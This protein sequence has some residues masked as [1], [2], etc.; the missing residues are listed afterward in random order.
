ME[1][2]RDSSKLQPDTYVPTW[3][4]YQERNAKLCV[5][6]EAQFLVVTSGR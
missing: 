1:M 5:E 6:Q 3:H 2:S 4:H